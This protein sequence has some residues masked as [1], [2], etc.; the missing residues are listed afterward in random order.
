[1]PFLCVDYMHAASWGFSEMQNDNT[2]IFRTVVIVSAEIGSQN[3]GL[4][5]IEGRRLSVPAV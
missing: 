3:N 4:I 2:A 1:M 5:T